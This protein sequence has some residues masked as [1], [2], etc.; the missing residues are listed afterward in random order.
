MQKVVK[1]VKIAAVF[2]I[3]LAMYIAVD[4]WTS[5]RIHKIVNND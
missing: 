3:T 1:G 4:E 2:A 5:D